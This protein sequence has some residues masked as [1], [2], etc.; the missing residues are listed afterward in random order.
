MSKSKKITF[1]M[2]AAD[3]V[4]PE[5]ETV[6]FAGKNREYT[7]TVKRSLDISDAMSF[8]D[9]IVLPCADVSSGRYSPEL[10]DL[11]VRMSTL[12]YYAGFDVPEPGEENV[13]IAYDVLYNTDIYDRVRAVVDG[14]QFQ[15]LVYGAKECVEHAKE[16]IVSSQ[17]SRLNELLE[18]MDAMMHDGAAAIEELSDSKMVTGIGDLLRAI[19]AAKASSDGVDGGAGGNNIIELPTRDE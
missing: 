6:V 4:K 2:I 14:E 12:V 16:M 13:A 10:F 5:N 9:S 1:G 8:I 7:I 3:M 11:M 17:A 18:K 15:S 19:E